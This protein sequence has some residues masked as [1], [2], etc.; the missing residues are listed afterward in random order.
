[1]VSNCCARSPPENAL[2]SSKPDKQAQIFQHFG[3]TLS[4]VTDD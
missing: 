4:P 2:T 3:T 1:M